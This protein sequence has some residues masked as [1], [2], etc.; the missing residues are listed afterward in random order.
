MTRK[1][2]MQAVPAAVIAKEMEFE[3]RS[4]KIKM[5]GNLNPQRL[6][7]SSFEDRAGYKRI[8]VSIAFCNESS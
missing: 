1:W 5:C 7:G 8:D 2:T 3:L 6:F 4:I